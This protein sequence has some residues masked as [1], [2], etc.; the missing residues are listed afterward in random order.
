MAS[1][2]SSTSAKKLLTGEIRFVARKYVGKT[3]GVYDKSRGSWPIRTPDTGEVEQGTTQ[4]VAEVTAEAL[5]TKVGIT[6]KP[7]PEPKKR[8]ATKKPAPEP[9]VKEAEGY[10]IEEFGTD[11]TE[12]LASKYEGSYL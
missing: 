7:A 10:D 8:A 11:D 3:W 6:V 1:A 2:S 12:E 5:N 4:A 9:E